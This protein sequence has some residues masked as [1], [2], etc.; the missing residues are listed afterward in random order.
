MNVSSTGSIRPRPQIVPCAATKAGLNAV[1]EGLAQALGP[2]VRLSTLMAGPFATGAIKHRLDA[3]ERLAADVGSDAP[4]RIGAPHEVVG[5]ALY[6][7]SDVSAYTS[8]A[9]LRV[10]GGMP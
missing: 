9:A 2:T 8:G 7:M 3:P 1:T 5:A 6:L 10:D 4:R